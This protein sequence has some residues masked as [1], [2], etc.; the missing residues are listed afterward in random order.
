[1][2][3]NSR[4]TPP[5]RA[6]HVGD[7]LRVIDCLAELAALRDGAA[8]TAGD[9]AARTITKRPG[10]R[11]VL[12]ALKP[13]GRMNEHHADFPITLHG[14]QGRVTLTVGNQA[15]RLVPGVLVTLAQGIL[16]SLEATDEGAVLLTIGGKD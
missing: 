3:T 7:P 11:V 13:G 5:E 10:I 15:V 14:L 16:H 8:Y 2:E 9:H 1:M 12:I 6:P 4:E